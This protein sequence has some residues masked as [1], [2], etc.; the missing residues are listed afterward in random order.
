MRLKGRRSRTPGR[1][2]V[3][4]AVAVQLVLLVFLS[5]LVPIPVVYLA[6]RAEWQREL[7]GQAEALA[8]YLARSLEV[9]LWEIDEPS[10]R[11]VA[12]AYANNQVV[13]RIRV[14]DADGTL[15]ED[16]GEAIPGA[17]IR[18]AP[19]LHD[20]VPIGA[21]EVALD[22]RFTA[23]AARRILWSNVLVTLV[24]AG[25]IA[26]GGFVL[27]SQHVRRPL[28]ELGLA[29]DR[30]AEGDYGYSLQAAVPQEF[31]S[32]IE[33]FRNMA[34][35][36]REREQALEAMNRQLEL[37][38]EER[39]RAERRYRDLFENAVEGIFVSTPQGRLVAANPALARM[40]G[41]GSPEEALA[42]VHD[43]PSQLYVRPDQRDEFLALLD[44]D[45]TVVQYEIQG[46][47]RDGRVIDLVVSARALRDARGRVERIQGFVL[48]VTRQ[49]IL[50]RRIRQ[51]QKMEAVGTLA[52]GVAHDFN[53]LLQAILG[54]AE[55]LLDIVP[56]KDRNVRKSLEGIR[57][58]A[59]RGKELTEQLL[60]FSRQAPARKRPV[61]L[62]AEIHAVFQWLRR[63]LPRMIR[64]D[65]DLAEDLPPVWADPA[66]VDQVFMN[67][68]V[69][70]RDAMPE[71]G[72]LRVRTRE[73]T[74]PDGTPED[75][76]PGR[77]V[78]ITVADTGHGMSP[79]VLE[80]I[81]EP[82]FTTKEVGEGTGLGL[83]TVYGIV[84][85]H[86]G[87]VTCDSAPGRGTAFRI[88][89]PATPERADGRSEETG[90]E[91]VRAAGAGT[92][93]VV[94]DEEMVR[95]VCED[96]LRAAG[97]RVL[98]A[99]DGETALEVYASQSDR[100]D[101]VLLDLSM[102]G[103]GGRRC[104]KEL[105]AR[106]PSARVVVATG[107][108]EGDQLSEL[109]GEGALRILHKPY[110][111]GELLRV[112][113]EVLAAGSSRHPPGAEGPQ[114]V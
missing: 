55:L 80:H 39:I 108:L 54:Y 6:A 102:P 40:F 15:L 36:V 113:G 42:F 1:R 112:V 99:P 73:A 49:K 74:A 9:P 8:T 28:E 65:L 75:L 33:R 71:G 100:I 91:P 85:E 45:G 14:W 4:T 72:V 35:R 58:A 3:A 107:Y 56:R 13:A 44:R 22:P 12:E 104:L 90:E 53:N 2:S 97:Y 20:G 76:A 48:D 69:N 37:E 83:A 21:V 114:R 77:Y 47:T 34:R 52:G 93:L 5:C 11:A 59:L 87:A 68:V 29:L 95:E 98:T 110:R 27:V 10:R 51:A 94:D 92:V 78:E 31:R 86:G 62:N 106:H 24:V 66:Q 16:Q 89:L 23:A 41:F 19:V 82:F 26:W 30:L 67:L 50:E 17:V 81:F 32:V 84:Q 57:N 61:D 38:V 25:A 18:R 46:R 103:M 60:A 96:V 64:V 63:T 111:S 70:A 109:L 79:E 88:Y 105:I 101:L 43:I 7:R